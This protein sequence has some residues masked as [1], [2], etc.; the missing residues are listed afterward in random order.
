MSRVISGSSMRHGDP[1]IQSPGGHPFSGPGNVAQGTHRSACHHP[2]AR[3][4]QQQ[5]GRQRDEKDPPYP[6][7]LRLHRRVVESDDEGRLRGAKHSQPPGALGRPHRLESGDLGEYHR[8]RATRSR[9]QSPT[10]LTSAP[11]PPPGPMELAPRRPFAWPRPS[12][13]APGDRQPTSNRAG[14]DRSPPAS[15]ATCTGF[16]RGCP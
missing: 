12:T 8:C 6:V 1:L 9:A 5:R 13:P 16:A 10:S 7:Q 14:Q 3:P 11:L 2:T 15:P 4:N